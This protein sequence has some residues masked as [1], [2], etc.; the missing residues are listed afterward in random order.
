[1][2]RAEMMQHAEAWVSAW[3]R[4]DLDAILAHFADDATF[5]SPRALE[6]TGSAEVRGK[7]ALRRYWQK[8]LAQVDRLDFRLDRILWDGHARE[9]AVVYVSKRDGAARRAIE[10]MRFDDEGRQIGGEALYGAPV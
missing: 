8:A 3:N 2:E 9:L 4:K 5:V 7:D 6:I 1:M 10:L